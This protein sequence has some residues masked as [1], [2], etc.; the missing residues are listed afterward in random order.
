MTQALDPVLVDSVPRQLDE[1]YSQRK[2][3]WDEQ[4]PEATQK[5]REDAMRMIADEL[6]I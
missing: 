6:G 5:E 1:L 2:R 4:N 3:E